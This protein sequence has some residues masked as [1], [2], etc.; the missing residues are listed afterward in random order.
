MASCVA[1]Q[2]GYRYRVYPDA[3]RPG[4]HDHGHHRV[5]YLENSFPVS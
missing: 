2:L 4:E 1:V 3:A 5:A